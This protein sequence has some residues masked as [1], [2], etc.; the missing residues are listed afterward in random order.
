MG[1]GIMNN[2]LESQI[3]NIIKQ[4][5]KAKNILS[6]ISNPDNQNRIIF[7]NKETAESFVSALNIL[8]TII[9]EDDWNKYTNKS[10]S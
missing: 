7:E 3:K 8:A 6:D 1:M 2:E 5:R 9:A 4:V 10:Q